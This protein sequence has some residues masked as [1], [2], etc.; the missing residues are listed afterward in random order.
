MMGYKIFNYK[1][2]TQQEYEI[3]DWKRK[4]A[5]MEAMEGVFICD[6]PVCSGNKIH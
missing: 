3:W 2:T 1:L 6:I 4:T 5:L